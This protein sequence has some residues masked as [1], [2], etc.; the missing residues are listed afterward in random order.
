MPNATVPTAQDR[1]TVTIDE[2][3]RMLGVSRTT[4]YEAAKSGQLPTI[5]LGR[6][7]LVPTAVLRRMLQLDEPNA[8]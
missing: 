6:R 2:A 4:A 5:S 7:L 1:P 8:V 3:C